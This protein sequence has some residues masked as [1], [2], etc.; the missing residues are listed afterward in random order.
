M[1]QTCRRLVVPCL[2]VGSVLALSCGGHPSS[3][4]QISTGVPSQTTSTA[5]EIASIRLVDGWTQD[6]VDVAQVTIDGKTYAPDANG[7]VRFPGVRNDE[8]VNLDIAAPGYLLRQTFISSAPAVTL[9][10]ANPQDRDAI[11]SM[12]YTSSGEVVGKF[13]NSDYIGTDDFAVG[14]DFAR[15][16]E[17]ATLFENLRSS[18]HRLSQVL[19]PGGADLFRLE[20]GP[21]LTGIDMALD[22]VEDAECSD[23]WGFCATPT[24]RPFVVHVPR[25]AAARPEVALRLLAQLFLQANPQAGLMNRARPSS[26]LSLLEQ[27]TLRMVFQRGY[28]N[29]W[30]D[31]DR[32]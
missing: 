31:N 20:P 17:G 32:P 22:V 23:S 24:S 1:D 7:V 5:V 21:S 27:Q 9:W 2:L 29:R 4:S 13:Y 12:A 15:S 3:P 25:S 28:V 30:E 19:S 11:K 10:P 6:V 16:S 8:H 14:G 26:E 18:E